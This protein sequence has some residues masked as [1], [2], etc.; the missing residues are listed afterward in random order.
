MRPHFPKRPLRGAFDI[1]VLQ[2]DT[3]GRSGDVASCVRLPDIQRHV[4]RH[5]ARRAGRKNL[6]PCEARTD[7][8]T[9]PERTSPEASDRALSG[10]DPPETKRAAAR[11]TGDGPRREGDGPGE[12]A[13]FKGRARPEPGRGPGGKGSRAPRGRRGAG[14]PPR[15]AASV[16]RPSWY[17]RRSQ[18]QQ[19]QHEAADQHA[20]APEPALIIV[21]LG[22]TPRTPWG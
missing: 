3:V 15:R 22:W 21:G 10:A 11:D 8:S 13:A 1:R 5:Q 17:R 6:I 4:P 18:H 9:P 20:D 16:R 14:R 19:A 2:A 7:K 12:A